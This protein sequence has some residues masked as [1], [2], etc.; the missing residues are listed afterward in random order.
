MLGIKGQRAAQIAIYIS[1][2]WIE[3]VERMHN[4]L[5]R[6]VVLG[7]MGQRAAQIAISIS[8]IWMETVAQPT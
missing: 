8:C 2:I 4:L 1:C 6:T 5:Q 3:T 7:I